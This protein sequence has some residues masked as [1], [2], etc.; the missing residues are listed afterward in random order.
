M[1]L[2][3]QYLIANGFCSCFFLVISLALLLSP[4]STGSFLN[5]IS[6]LNFQWILMMTFAFTVGII[7]FNAERSYPNGIQNR[8]V[9]QILKHV[10]CSHVH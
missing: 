3:G 4:Y 1:S 10:F 8:W 9:K 2:K 5:V 7:Y 6:D